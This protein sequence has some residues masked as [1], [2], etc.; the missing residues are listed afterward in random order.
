MM[1]RRR[2]L[3]CRSQY[4]NCASLPREPCPCSVLAPSNQSMRSILGHH[5][6]RIPCCQVIAS[7]WRGTPSRH[8][9]S[10]CTVTAQ[11]TA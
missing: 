10:N 7:A 5:T 2:R 6:R 4:V 8:E 11:S 9:R 3:A 1:R